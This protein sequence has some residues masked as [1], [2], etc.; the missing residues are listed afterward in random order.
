MADTIKN[1]FTHIGWDQENT[2][3]PSKT[4]EGDMKP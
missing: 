2:V 1:D 4:N 3:P